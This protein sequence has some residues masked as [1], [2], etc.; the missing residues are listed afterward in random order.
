M[1]LVEDR[2]HDDREKLPTCWHNLHQR[3]PRRKSLWNTSL[4]R[5]LC[6]PPLLAF[7]PTFLVGHELGLIEELIVR[8]HSYLLC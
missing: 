8:I 5:P 1:D 6:A 4:Q 3:L 2:V 7:F